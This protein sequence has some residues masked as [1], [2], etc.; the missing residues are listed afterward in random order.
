MKLFREY[1]SE[2]LSAIDSDSRSTPPEEEF[3]DGPDQLAGYI[4]V[5]DNH[6]RNIIAYA[7]ITRTD[8]PDRPFLVRTTDTNWHI[9][10]GIVRIIYPGVEDVFNQID[11][12][13]DW[14]NLGIGDR[15]TVGL[16][17]WEWV[18]DEPTS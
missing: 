9:P 3:V 14:R 10:F 5:R 13:L 18:E 7:P 15:G 12:K 11:S 1:I 4:V 6:D 16:Y 2:L 17:E 8:G